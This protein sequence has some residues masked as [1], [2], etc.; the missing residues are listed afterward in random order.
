MYITE[1]FNAY[2]LLKIRETKRIFVLLDILEAFSFFDT[3][4][5]CETQL[6]CSPRYYAKPSVTFLFQCQAYF[7]Y[8]K[9][10]KVQNSITYAKARR[11]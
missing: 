4:G 9:N 6:S 5:I 7:F 8:C 10:I 1:I 11:E 3:F 2:P